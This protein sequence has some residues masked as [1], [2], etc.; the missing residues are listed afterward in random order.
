MQKMSRLYFPVVKP[1]SSYHTAN[2]LYNGNIAQIDWI[3]NSIDA[4]PCVSTYCYQYDGLNRILTADYSDN[5][6]RDFSTS[7][8]YDKNGNI[9]TLTRMG[10][11]EDQN[12]Q[13]D[14]LT[15]RYY[16]NQLTYV[17]DIND[18]NHQDYGFKDNGAFYPVQT[19]HGVSLPPDY[20]YDANG[21]L[22]K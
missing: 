14:N 18:P 5:Q 8:S 20:S 1:Y 12:I 15:Y 11:Y 9:L 21:N 3:S 19:R 13:I 22:I 2:P 16:G 17:D 4:P 7:Y 6:Q 10:Y